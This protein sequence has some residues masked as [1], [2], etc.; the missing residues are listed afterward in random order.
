MSPF[1]DM[2]LVILLVLGVDVLVSRKKT[3]SLVEEVRLIVSSNN[4][5]WFKFPESSV[6]I[7]AL[8]QSSDERLESSRFEYRNLLDNEFLVDDVI[9]INDESETVFLLAG[10]N[11]WALME[12]S[13][14][15]KLKFLL[16]GLNEWALMELSTLPILL[17][18]LL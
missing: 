4:V 6:N 18:R 1:A 3:S 14:L 9:V 2:L 12:L 16:I 5:A 7:S 17:F 10:L 11:V 8:S 13:T 15:P